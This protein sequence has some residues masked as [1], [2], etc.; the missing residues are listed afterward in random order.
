MEHIVLGENIKHIVYPL[1]DGKNENIANFFESFYDLV[2]ESIR[3]GNIL[4]HCAAGI[5]RVSDI[6]V[7]AQLWSFPTSW[8]NK[9][10]PSKMP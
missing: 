3:N 1:L 6:I 10:W 7:R 9:K 2:E 4:V 5:S 8:K